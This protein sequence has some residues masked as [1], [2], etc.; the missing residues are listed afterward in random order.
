MLFA[1]KMF[2]GLRKNAARCA[3]SRGRSGVRCVMIFAALTISSGLKLF[4]VFFAA[5]RQCAETC[6]RE[7]VNV[8][9]VSR[10][11]YG[12]LRSHWCLSLRSRRCPPRGHASV[13]LRSVP[14]CG[15]VS[16][17]P[18]V[19]PAAITSVSLFAVTSVTLLAVTLVSL[20]CGHVSD[21]PRG[22]VSVPPL[23]SRQC[24]SLRS[25]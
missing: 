10:R 3:N 11:R 9:R 25:R 5:K 17:P 6:K 16:V 8:E 7:T 12:S 23:R 24:P 1:A 15:H 4:A 20:H 2:S 18:L 22:H 21:P 19:P 14:A 13:P